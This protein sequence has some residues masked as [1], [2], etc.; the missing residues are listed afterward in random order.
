[1]YHTRDA[2]GLS[3]MTSD[4]PMVFA[5]GIFM[6]AGFEGGSDQPIATIGCR[7]S[8]GKID[9]GKSDFKIRGL[10]FKV[11]RGDGK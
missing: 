11:Q 10:R 3:F 7:R 4:I 1:M 8:R 6:C 2:M 5:A 9:E